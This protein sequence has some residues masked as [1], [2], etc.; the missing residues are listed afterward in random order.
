ML[1]EVITFYCEDGQEV[2]DTTLQAYRLA[3]TVNLPVMVV[4]DAFFL[5]HTFEPVDIPDQE[6]V[7]HFLL[8]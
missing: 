6:L 8:V 4:L 3:E 7:D 2:F 1:Y 5:S